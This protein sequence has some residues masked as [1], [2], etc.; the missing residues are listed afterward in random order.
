MDMMTLLAQILNPN[1]GA[2]ANRL[3]H[4]PRME[5]ANYLTQPSAGMGMPQQGFSPAPQAA[6]PAA[7]A[8]Q[9][10]PQQP[11]MAPSAPAPSPAPSGGGIGG[12][13]SNLFQGPNAG[14]ND[15]IQWLVGQGYDEGTARAISGNKNVVQSILLDRMKGQKP[16][17]V[18][19]RLVDP[20]TYEVVADFSTPGNRQTATIDGKLVDTNTGEVIGDYGGGDQ[21]SLMTPQEVEAAGL[22]P[23]VYQRSADGKID[24]V[25]SV[26]DQ[27]AGFKNEMELRKEYDMLP[28]VKDYKIVK[29]NFERI[30]QG[31][32]LGTGA[33][34]AAIVFGYMKMLDPTS[35]VRESEQATAQNA[36]G[37]PESVRGLW[38]QVSGGGQ[39]SAEARNQILQAAVK[40]YGES[41][42][43][44]EQVNKRYGEYADTWKLDPNR[45]VAPI[46]QYEPLTVQPPPA[47]GGLPLPPPPGAPA[48]Q[49]APAPIAPA[50]VAPSQG[51]TD[52][53]DWIRAP[54]GPGY[55]GAK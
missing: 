51:V 40:V 47:P 28:E 30:Q 4:S 53:K 50:P 21:V 22:P 38:N 3:T 11:A 41:A 16:I 33:G 26:R 1:P 13:L 42:A 12:F 39:L 27:D 2:Q 34:D 7:F 35:V 9:Q 6:Q 19:G 25:G 8:P 55:R 32:Q 37:V 46:E 29:N 54:K 36:A 48:A 52:W 49:S 31:V 14:R 20:N 24:A 18:N 44:I 23:G 15:T 10:A 43:N 45:I 5:D 17:E